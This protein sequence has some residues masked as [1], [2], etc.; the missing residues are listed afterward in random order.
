MS[1]TI[2]A[3]VGLHLEGCW[4]FIDVTRD[5][6]G[7]GGGRCVS[8]ARGSAPT[9]GGESGS[10][11]NLAHAMSVKS[12]RLARGVLSAEAFPI[13]DGFDIAY[14]VTVVLG[15][16]LGRKVEHQLL[17]DFCSAYHIPTTLATRREKRRVLDAGA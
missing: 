3:R 8:G 5:D 14:V 6:L 10:A 15:K 2:C 1:L 17:A 9:G 12:G 4:P 11:A 7:Y 13:M 16:L